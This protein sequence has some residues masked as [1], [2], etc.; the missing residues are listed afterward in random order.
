MDTDPRSPVVLAPHFAFLPID[1]S[2]GQIRLLQLAPGRVGEPVRCSYQIASVDEHVPY[3]TLSYV[4]GAMEGNKTIVVEGTQA[5]LT[6]NL[7]DALTRIRHETEPRHLWV[8]ALCINQQD[9]EEKT[10]Q[11]NMMHR[12]YANCM[13]CN[14]WMGRID[15]ATIGGTEA[16]ALEA[17][18][19]ALDAVRVLAGKE[20]ANYLSPY[21]TNRDQKMKAGKALK[22]LMHTRWWSRIWTVQ[23]ATSPKDAI[24]LWGPVSIPWSF[25]M[26]AA[27]RLMSGDWPPDEQLAIPDLFEHSNF[28]WFTAPILGLK[29]ASQWIVQPQTPLDMLWR[30]RYR[31]STDPR[32]KVYVI[33]NLVAEGTFP[34]PTIPSSDYTIN[35]AVLY[36]RV[37]LDLFRYETGLRPL[38]GLRGERKSIPNLPSWVVDWSLPPPEF[39][40]AAF[41]ENDHFW[42]YYTADRGLPMLNLDEMTSPEHGEDVLNV[43]GVF[44]DK[45]LVCSDLIARH[46]EHSRIHEMVAE[47]I[48]KALA[49]EPRYCVISEVYWQE[50][51]VNIIEGNYADSEDEWEGSPGDEFWRAEMLRYQRLFITKNGAVGLGPSGTSIG[52]EVWILSGGRWPFLLSPIQPDDVSVKDRAAS[53][54]YTFRGEVFIPGIMGGEAVDSRIDSQRFVHI[55]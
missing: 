19:G 31:D 36:R 47:V 52:D 51:L 48:A 55:H 54:H 5:D 17:A 12:I 40:S 6:D 23:E 24:V 32:D 22:E 28:A 1:S 16:E 53:Y 8:D 30:F 29:W 41:W 42:L 43:N 44:F 49:E 7:F 13:Q 27:E 25:M 15:T 37:M 10:A 18:K 45:V 4:W 3:Q 33:L 20:S 14:M 46:E 50:A 38:I 39:A 35:T 9:G 26:L 34:L 2:R 11:V 21:L